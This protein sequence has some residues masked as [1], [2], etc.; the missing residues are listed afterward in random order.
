MIFNCDIV[1][2]GIFVF[3][4]SWTV[5]NKLKLMWLMIN[6]LLIVTNVS[7]RIHLTLVARLRH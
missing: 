4:F 6:G 1:A 3:E 5:V 2:I 7:L